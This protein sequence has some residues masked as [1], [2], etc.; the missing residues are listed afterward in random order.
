[1][2]A[3]EALPTHSVGRRLTIEPGQAVGA[4]HLFIT[5]ANEGDV[6]VFA[7]DIWVHGFPT[8]TE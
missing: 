6:V 2:G 8:E 1:M 4:F 5:L 7:A 3:Y